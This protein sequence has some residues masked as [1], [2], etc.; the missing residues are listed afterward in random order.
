[1]SIAVLA[2][3][4]DTSEFAN[5]FSISLYEKTA[6]APHRPWCLSSPCLPEITPR[7]KPA[8]AT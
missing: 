3:I 4:P 7:E 1:M 5:A 8:L 6:L 2:E